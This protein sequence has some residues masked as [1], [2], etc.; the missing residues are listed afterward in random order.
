MFLI[1]TET[2][3][4]RP[5]T[6]IQ[7]VSPTEVGNKAYR[8]CQLALRDFPIP[9]S[10]VLPVGLYENHIRHLGVQEQITNILKAPASPAIQDDLLTIREHILGSELASSVMKAVRDFASE[11]SAGTAVRS[12][13]LSEDT[14]SRSAAG[15]FATVLN[16]QQP[17][18]IEKGIL[19][20]WSS[21]WT[22][23]AIRYTLSVM[24]N[25]V[26][27]KM[28]VMLMEMIDSDASGVLFTE[29]PITGVRESVIE[30]VWGLGEGLVSKG[31]TPDRLVFDEEMR[32]KQSDI[33]FKPKQYR[34][35]H[36][37]GKITKTDVA[38]EK[39]KIPAV[40]G[41][42]M[43][44]LCGFAKEIAHLCNSPQDIEWSIDRKG[45][46]WILQSR[47]ITSETI[48]LPAFRPPGPGEWRVIDHIANPG[49]RCFAEY[50]FDP[51]EAGWNEDALRIGT[52]N[53]VKVREIN[54]FMYF[55]MNP[56][57]TEQE[58]LQMCQRLEGYW[59]EKRYLR[60]LREWDEEVKPLA[61]ETLSALQEIPRDK[62]SDE[63][64]L[65]YF[66]HCFQVTLDMT[67]HHHRFTYTSFIPIGDFVRQVCEWTD[68]KPSSVLE[69]LRG[70]D[71]NR[72]VM[73]FKDPEVRALMEALR[74]NQMAA[75]LLSTLGD[76]PE[77]AHETLEQLLA[78]GG[79]I[80]QGLNYLFSC[81]GY[82]I[83]NGYDITSD[84]FIERPDIILSAISAMLNAKDRPDAHGRQENFETIR[85]RVPKDKKAQFDEMLRDVREMDRLRDERG[86]FCDL[87]AI[88][89]LRHAFLE[90]G[91]RLACK[92]LLE[93]PG[94]ILDASTQ[95]VMA[96]L[97]DDPV[98]TSEA[99]RRRSQYRRRYSVTD[100]PPVLGSDPVPPP[101]LSSLPPEMARTMAGLMTTVKLALEHVHIEKEDDDNV[102]KGVPASG[103]IV[104]GSA[105][106][107][108]SDEQIRDIR[109]GEI[110]VVY[111][112]TAM[113]NMV[114]PLLRGV[115]S[116]FGGV[117]SHPAILSREYNIPC[118]VGCSGVMEH[119]R[120]GMRIRLDAN[121]GKVQI[122]SN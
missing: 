114:F 32:K 59:Q 88:G 52:V 99:L 112:T 98:I 64:F 115:I 62:L 119:I 24:K 110:L 106:V 82:R 94:L 65:R 31:L 92:G 48:P 95:E 74:D 26:V 45:V 122:I 36:G 54:G 25:A 28:A 51:V 37:S 8:C 75:E 108:H 109:E 91:K 5:I 21:L 121:Q 29:N 71:P 39:Q 79:A 41:E 84:T 13:A 86:L 93:S 27:P 101:D 34:M 22:P 61:T 105:R 10:L 3:E 67:R 49:T 43:R 57:D 42:E 87:W 53:R 33:A 107:I 20:C 68:E 46:L 76:K 35:T 111:Q 14:A 77:N 80:E 12:S 60:V 19:E 70:C 66:E 38:I 120:S 96:L 58:F 85:A 116:Q 73:S 63:A 104:E 17:E 50:Y 44:K 97:Q 117:L 11:F 40:T 7:A 72:L 113:F 18:D 89:I 78:C 83:V 103:G 55:Q 9:N 4:V 118:I 81:S 1:F 69:L 16:C 47:D 23:H 30:A 100:V 6:E 90:A 56:V 15:Q 2:S 102:W